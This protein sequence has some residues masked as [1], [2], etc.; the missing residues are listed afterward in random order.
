ML[1][2]VKCEDML[3]KLSLCLAL[4]TV[5]VLTRCSDAPVVPV[6]PSNRAVLAEI[7]VETT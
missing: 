5:V 6:R 2:K 1:S 4:G 3:R 7:V